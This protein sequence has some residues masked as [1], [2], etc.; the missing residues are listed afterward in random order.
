VTAPAYALPEVASSPAAP[1]RRPLNAVAGL[2][3]SLVAFAVT[4]VPMLFTG[5]GHATSVFRDYHP[6]D[7]LSY[8]AMVVNGSQGLFGAVEPFTE[9]GRNDYPRLYYLVLGALSRW[10]GASPV[11]TWVTVGLLLQGLLVLG[12]GVACWLLTRKP[13]TT[14][15]AWTPF[16]VGTFS[17]LV[18]GDWFSQI[19]SHAV[20]WGLFGT[21]FTLNAEA[22]ALC[23]AG[24]ILLALIVSAQHRVSR[25]TWWV[26]GP[27]CGAAVGLLADIHTYTFVTAVYLVAYGAAAY[28]LATRE[29]RTWA[30]VSLGLVPVTFL[31][32]PFVAD[33]LGA[34]AGLGVGLLPALPGLVGLLA[35]YRGL[36]AVPAASALLAASPQIVGTLVRQHQGD[37]FLRYRVASSENLTVDAGTGVACAVVLLVPLAL[38]FVAGLRTSNRCWLAYP[39]AFVLVWFMLSKNELWGPEQEPYR[40]WIE[41]FG[42]CVVTLLPVGLA[43]ATSPSERVH[44]SGRV[45]WRPIVLAGASALL[46][47]SAVDWSA[48][49]VK[50]GDT[51]GWTFASPRSRALQ[52]VAAKAGNGLILPDPC[53]DPRLLKASTGQRVAFF[54]EGM[55]WPAHKREIQRLLDRREQ[56]RLPSGVELAAADVG[57]VLTDSRCGSGSGWSR[58]SAWLRRASSADYE[59][60]AG[61]VRIELWR[62]LPPV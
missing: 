6:K 30:A 33:A 17:W 23:L 38:I 51:G 44:G 18:S 16:V 45:R 7:Q 43:A 20:L 36:V 21:L 53:V 3:F 42:L 14:F 11:A 55:A 59:S 62:V 12:V 57:W 39:A 31:V 34:L 28:A 47:L 8:F 27:A 32:G 61:T 29:T 15:L 19:R 9:T 46:V 10:T 22:A 41:V 5:A 56:R 60:A 50:V 37:P 35:T 48:F 13:W 1:R 52:V 49:Y 26:V 25:R 54:N 40:F 24:V 4:Q 2:C 58:G